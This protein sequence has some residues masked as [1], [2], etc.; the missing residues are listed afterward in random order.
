MKKIFEIYIYIANLKWVNI[1]K[2]R[3]AGNG[4][5]FWVIE[6]F[7][8]FLATYCRISFS[9]SILPDVSE[10]EVSWP[11][12]WPWIFGRPSNCWIS[13]SCRDRSSRPPPAKLEVI[14]ACQ[15]RFAGN[16]GSRGDP[17]TVFLWRRERHIWA[18]VSP[19][20]PRD[21]HSMRRIPRVLVS[22]TLLLRRVWRDWDRHHVPA[23]CLGF[24]D[25]LEYC[26]HKPHEVENQLLEKWHSRQ[27]L[28][29]RKRVFSNFFFIKS[30]CG[31]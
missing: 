27:H 29:D 11:P 24:L 2:Y 14:S 13:W 28:W 9:Q 21:F 5:G 31:M 8:R 12:P 6:A 30:F 25:D 3:K 22:R 16:S 4:V 7:W 23:A 19:L 15:P 10:A 26:R 17:G 18:E 1:S 20:R